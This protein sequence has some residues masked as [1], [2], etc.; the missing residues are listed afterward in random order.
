MHTLKKAM[1]ESGDA[2]KKI[3]IE[4]ERE[5]ERSRDQEIKRSRDQDVS[6]IPD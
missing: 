5:N 4:R 1:S 6:M 3:N 2:R